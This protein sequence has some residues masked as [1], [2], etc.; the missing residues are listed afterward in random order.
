M[1]KAKK[2]FIII[3]MLIIPGYHCLGA[4]ELP[5]NKLIQARQAYDQGQYQEAI[6]LYQELLEEGYDNG[7]L[8]FNLGNAAYKSGQLGEALAF[9]RRASS[10][11]P[12]DK[13]I[14][15]NINYIR[16]LVKQPMQKE[17]PI[18]YLTKHFFYKLSAQRLSKIALVFYLLL[19]ISIGALILKKNQ[20]AGWK[21]GAAGLGLLFIFF[22]VV[23]SARLVVAKQV[24]WG[25]VVSSQAEARNG[26]GEDY[27][28]GFTV[29]EGR[30]VRIL[31]T[32]SDWLA[33]GLVQEG[34]KGW[35]KSSDIWRD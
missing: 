6:D 20:H 18:D 11:L 29:P 4:E 9:F 5:H 25:V 35:V 24:K 19:I 15:H 17:N 3:S 26:P 13:D 28:V 7:E 16:Q 1:S 10:R 27:Q 12:W 30:E 14:E 21:W 31:G 32:E 34:Y 22:S 23:A 33:I 2:V 8:Y